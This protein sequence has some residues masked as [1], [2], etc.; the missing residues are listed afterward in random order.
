MKRSLLLL[1]L[2]AAV[3]CAE[4]KE[5]PRE[6]AVP[7]TVATV[8]QK[9]MPLGIQAIGNVQ[10]LSTVAVRALV[11]GQLLNVSFHEGDD[12]TKGQ[13]LFTIDSRPYVAAM[14]QAQANLARDE[15]QLR[16]GESNAARYADLVKKDYVTKEE[17]DRIASG[18]EAARAVVAADRAAVENARLQLSYCTIRAPLSGRTGSLQVHAGNLV[19]ANDTTPLVVINQVE[20]VYVQFAIP[21]DQL[22]QI[23][24]RGAATF[25]VAAS[26]QS[27]GAA[28]AHGKLSFV[29]NAVDTSTGTITLK[30]LFDNHDRALWPGQFVT[31]SMTIEDRPSAIVVPA[32]AVQIGQNGQFVYVVKPGNAVE[33][34]QISVFRTIGQETIVADG[35]NAGETVVT[36]GQLR[37]TPKSKVEIKG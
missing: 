27:G 17:Y 6:E 12:V 35:L 33:M 34:R 25:A 16:N 28:T 18:A 14:Q 13:V 22:A 9:D 31:V 4:K 3:A 20:P 21:Q 11:E 32:R 5:A 24:A 8:Q 2:I 36:D 7:V 30:A 19:H 29:D 37:L 23:R 15:A 26:P 1:S 10:P